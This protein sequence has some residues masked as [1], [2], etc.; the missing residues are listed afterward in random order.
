ML[1]SIISSWVRQ[2]RHRAKKHDIY[3]DLD[4]D[5]VEQI[6]TEHTTCAYCAAEPTTLDHPFPLKDIAPNVPANVLP[7]CRKCKS[8]KKYNDM[9]WMFHTGRISN[10]LYLKLIE[11]LVNRRGGNRIKEHIK[12]VTG[13]DNGT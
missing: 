2:A 10:E 1:K 6:I 11:T 3:N 8:V 5:D 9:V 12:L 13:I 7:I 4:I